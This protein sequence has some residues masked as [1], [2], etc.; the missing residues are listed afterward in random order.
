[1]ISNF[2]INLFDFFLK[3]EY[4]WN[5]SKPIYDLNNLRV[6]IKFYKIG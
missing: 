6:I 5:D 3:T 1:M 2:L 4:F